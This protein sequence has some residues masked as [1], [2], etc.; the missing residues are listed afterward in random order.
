MSDPRLWAMPDEY[1]AGAAR[2][3]SDSVDALSRELHPLLATVRREKVADLPPNDEGQPAV[4][5]PLYRGIELQHVVTWDIEY[6]LDGSVE[7]FLGL[8]F[9]L[10]DEMGSQMVRGMLQHISDIC[11]ASGQTISAEGREYFDV[12]AETLE[13]I[14]MSFDEDGKPN[15]VMVLNPDTARRLEGRQPSPEQAERM[16]QILERRKEEWDAERRRRDLP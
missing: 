8:V 14:D 12:V 7:V 10:A 16:R 6:V 4:A 2:W 1:A 5:S 13:T 11:D 3:V 15:L 9:N